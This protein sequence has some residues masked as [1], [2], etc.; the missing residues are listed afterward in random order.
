MHVNISVMQ[1]SR[2]SFL[3]TLQD[4]MSS[5]NISPKNLSLEITES[6]LAENQGI[7]SRN[8]EAILAMGIHVSIDDFGTGYSS[9]SYLQELEFDCLKIDRAFVSTLTEANF[10]SSLTAMILNISKS[11]DTYAV[12]EGIETEMQAKLLNELD[13]QL[14]Q[15]Y[16]FGRPV[17]YE[18]W[19]SS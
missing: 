6:G 2:A 10:K 17:P 4:I 5:T 14:G 16:Y 7:F 9:L 1:L 3:T 12:A 15:G 11:I 19:Q 13:C 18:S 8:L